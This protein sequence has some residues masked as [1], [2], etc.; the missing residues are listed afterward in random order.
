[1]YVC[2]YTPA[3]LIILS[4]YQRKIQ[5]RCDLEKAFFSNFCKQEALVQQYVSVGASVSGSRDFDWRINLNTSCKM[6]S[7]TLKGK[8]REY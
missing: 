5:L 1:M 3:P 2:V 4:M 7:Y 6:Y 8:K